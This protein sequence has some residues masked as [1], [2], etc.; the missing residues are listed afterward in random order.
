M[1]LPSRLTFAF[2]ISMIV[3]VS[4]QG[5]PGGLFDSDEVFTLT[6]TGNLVDLM[7]DRVGDP[8]YF[9]VQLSYKGADSSV[10]NIPIKART[11]GNFRRAKG[12][13]TY[14]PILLNFS[15]E[16]TKNTI[17]SEQSKVKLVMPCQGDKYVAREYLIYKV[18]NLVTPMSFRA[19]LVKVYLDDPNL[20]PKTTEAFYGILLE[21]EDQMAVRNG[22]VSV[23]RQLVRPELTQSETFLNMAV[24]EYLIGN[25]DWSVQ[26]RQN[27]KLIAA[28]TVSSRPYTVPYDFDHA[29]IVGAPYAKPAEELQMM[30]TK[31]R[32]YRGFCISDMV[33]F[34]KP[35]A[36]YN[37]LKDQIY[38]VYTNSKVVDDAYIKST[39]KYL[40]EFYKTINDPKKA[41][42]DFQYP[43]RKDGTGN[44]VIK[45]L[46]N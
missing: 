39:V 17:F 43:C 40:D 30:S 2:F 20:K 29:G 27:V 41:K 16:Q 26:Y 7:K 14:P 22:M 28:D 1:K 11:R 24:F 33:H 8:Q 9:D 32:R 12:T 19:R 35:F 36:L 10:V 23:D 5:Q 34:E 42:E 45:G 38:A 25:T 15:S 31:Q 3:C 4:A 21:E 6:L 18:Y 44:V 46:N 37:Q 13:C